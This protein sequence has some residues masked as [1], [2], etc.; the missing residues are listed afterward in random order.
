MNTG[1]YSFSISR[2]RTLTA[3]FK[4][5]LSMYAGVEGKARKGANLYIGVDGKARKAVHAYI[6]VNGKAIKF[7]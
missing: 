5:R 2:A 3:V 6:G 7:L 1:S 4:K